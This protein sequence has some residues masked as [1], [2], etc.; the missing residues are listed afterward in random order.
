MERLAHREDDRALNK[1]IP[2]KPAR[3]HAFRGGG[4]N[5]KPAPD[6]ILTGIQIWKSACRNRKLS[7]AELKVF[8]TFR[9]IWIAADRLELYAG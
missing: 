4:V 1:T 8:C 5:W 7:R 3:T 2:S 9:I 6:V